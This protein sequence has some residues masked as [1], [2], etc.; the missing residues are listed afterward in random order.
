[1][2]V[3]A[4]A[5]AAIDS[6]QGLMHMKLPMSRLPLAAG[7]LLLSLAATPSQATEYAFST[8]GLGGVAFGAG[9][10]PP[11]GVYVTEATAFL[12]STIGS[13]VTL[14]LAPAFSLGRQ[15]F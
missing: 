3:G 12:S 2:L 13:A 14:T 8:Y 10:T 7:F 5:P 9:V 4:G 6:N 1:M 15:T 11:P